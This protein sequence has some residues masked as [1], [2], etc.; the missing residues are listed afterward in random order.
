MASS[1]NRKRVKDIL[2]MAGVSEPPVDIERVAAA[3][4]YRVIPYPFPNK[5]KAIVNIDK[6]VIGINSTHPL[7]MQRFSAAHE[8]GHCLS[9]HE[10]RENA[11]LE[12]KE[13]YFD[14]YFHQEKEADSFASELL[15]PQDFLEQDLS[16][17]GTDIE[18]LMDLYQV[19]KEA[20]L[21]RLKSS[22]LIEKYS[23]VKTGS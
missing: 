5:G 8:L 16:K 14:P 19:S 11:F 17:I 22:R 15:M 1:L 23:H 3:L 20:L 13:R 21:I 9:G 12:G 2:I 18:K 4:G 6:K 7:P 10:H